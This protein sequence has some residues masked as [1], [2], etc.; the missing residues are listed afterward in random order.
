MRMTDLILKSNEDIHELTENESVRLKKTLLEIYK[1]VLSVCKNN[2]LT[3][4]LGGGSCIGAVRHNG[5]IPWDDDLDLL[6]FRKDYDVLPELLEKAFPGKYEVVVP[7]KSEKAYL[8]FYKIELK[9]TRL[10]TIYDT[11][12]QCG[13]AIDVFPVETIPMNSVH[14]NLHGIRITFLLYIALCVKLF[15]KH[16]LADKL[17]ASSLRGKTQHLF[18]KTVGFLFSWKSYQNWYHKADKIASKTYDSDMTSIPTGRKHY[19]GESQVRD[20]YLPA[21]TATFEGINSFIPKDFDRYL[22]SLYGDYM[23]IPPVEKRE[24]HFIVD[25]DFGDFAE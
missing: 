4:F 21:A 9:G 23:Q 22:S 7:G 18:R 13:I 2:N 10:V 15:K 6:M 25:I 19:W 17:I 12:E 14:R 5:F 16:S 20:V 11:D 1:D 3:C 24:K 8:A